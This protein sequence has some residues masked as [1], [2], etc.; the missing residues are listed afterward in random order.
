MV[1]V[2]P[3]N[4]MGGPVAGWSLSG[5]RPRRPWQGPLRHDRFPGCGQV[6]DEAA[7]SLVQPCPAPPV[8]D[9]AAKPARL[10]VVEASAAVADPDLPQAPPLPVPARAEE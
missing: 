7:T 9:T 10:N 4:P 3:C 8:T 1:P 2:V 5:V 6:Q